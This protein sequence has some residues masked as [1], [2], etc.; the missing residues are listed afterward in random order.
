[1][2]GMPAASAALTGPDSASTV[3]RLT[4]RPWTSWATA[5]LMKSPCCLR[6]SEV[7]KSSCA[8]TWAAASCPPVLTS[9]QKASPAP[10][11]T[12]IAIFTSPADPAAAP[13]V[14]PEFAADEQA[15]IAPPWRR[16]G[17]RPER[18]CD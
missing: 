18:S 3:G 10:P 12:T 13:D 16:S 1:M 11:W 6:S 7:W 5:A 17:R 9:L 2:T 15:V 8:P 4:I 14:E